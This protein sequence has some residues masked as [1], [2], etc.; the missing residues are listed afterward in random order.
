MHKSKRLLFRGRG[1]HNKLI[2]S[3][4]ISEIIV[5]GNKVQG[6]PSRKSLFYI[7]HYLVNRSKVRQRYLFVL[8]SPSSGYRRV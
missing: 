2:Q 3:F 5:M 4:N 6:I 8:N 1:K 7:N